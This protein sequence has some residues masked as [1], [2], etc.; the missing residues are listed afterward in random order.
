[1]FFSVGEAIFWTWARKPIRES[2]FSFFSERLLKFSGFGVA[3]CLII[4]FFFTN[5][6]D[7]VDLDNKDYEDILDS[8]NL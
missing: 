1:M 3:I 5:S 6:P 2:Y 7:H 8:G 4:S